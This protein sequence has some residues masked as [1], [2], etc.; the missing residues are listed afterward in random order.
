MIR[1]GRVVRGE[2]RGVLVRFERPA[3]CTGCGACA[4][5]QKTSTVFALGSAR[6]G[7]IVSVQM[8]EGA[9]KRPAWQN[10]LALTLG[11]G[12]GLLMGCLIRAEEPVMALGGA[13][14][15]AAGGAVLWGTD[16]GRKVNG[17]AQILS[18]ND[19]R[20]M[21]SYKKLSVCSKAT[22]WSG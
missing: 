8:P 21:E 12:C 17:Q 6:A 7:D 11:F 4:R 10:Y 13:L 18:V 3:A 9:K 1:I 22:G 20:V 15:L 14:G 16:K 19:P 2:G 5:D